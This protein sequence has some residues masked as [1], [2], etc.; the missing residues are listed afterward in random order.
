MMFNPP[1]FKVFVNDVDEFLRQA[2]DRVFGRNADLKGR[3]G[4]LP[5]SFGQEKET[6]LRLFDFRCFGKECL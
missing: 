6:Y 4:V 5:V 1:S 3:A 2:A